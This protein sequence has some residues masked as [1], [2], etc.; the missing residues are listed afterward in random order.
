MQCHA[1][2]NHALID[3]REDLASSLN[4]SSDTAQSWV[5]THVFPSCLLV[6]HD[7]R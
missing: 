6:V 3:I 5:K 4:V 2:S 7:P 1:C